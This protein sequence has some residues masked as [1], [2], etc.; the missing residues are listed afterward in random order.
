MRC[1]LD[2]RVKAETKR[3][4]LLRAGS[5]N[6]AS[7][8]PSLM[9]LKNTVPA[10][11]TKYGVRFTGRALLHAYVAP[12]YET[13]HCCINGWLLMMKE[14]RMERYNETPIDAS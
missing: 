1:R 8:N 2:S 11:A 7:A 6:R 4:A 12:V 5:S 13:S 14:M 9:H 3:D 10:S